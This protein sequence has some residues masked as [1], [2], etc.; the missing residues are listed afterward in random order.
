MAIRYI[1]SAYLKPEQA[2]ALQ[3]AIA[4]GSFGAGFPYGDLREV[5]Y[6]ARVD[7]DGRV[8]WIE[9]CYCRAAYGV[10]MKEELPF[11]QPY[12]T[13]IDVADARDPRGCK[14]Y[15]HCYEC[16]CTRKKK[17][18]G[19]PFMDVLD[20]VAAGRWQTADV[21]RREPRWLGW[22]GKVTAQEARLNAANGHGPGAGS[23]A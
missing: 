10:A 22:K 1:M 23:S 4:D 13:A 12:F 9:V 5:L 18:P 17:L 8:R 16:D 14:G 11:F 3:L 20:N 6:D 7:D 19:R 15:P 21:V 2:R